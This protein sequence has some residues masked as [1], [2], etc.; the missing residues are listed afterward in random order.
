MAIRI[1]GDFRQ[2]VRAGVCSLVGF[3]TLCA[4]AGAQAPPVTTG[5]VV[6]VPASSSWGQIYKILFYQGNVLALDSGNDAL[7]QLAPGATSWTTLVPAKTGILGGGFNAQGMAID[8]VGNLYITVAYSLTVNSTALFWR[9]PYQ[10]GTW[11]VGASDGWGANLVD[12]N[13]GNALTDSTELDGAYSV[14]VFFQN[15]SKMDGSGTLY[16]W[17]TS[18]GLWSAPVDNTGN[19]SQSS[20]NA[21]QILSGTTAGQ[22][23]I[24][25][26]AAGNIYFVEYHGVKNSGRDTGIWFIPAAAANPVTGGG[27]VGVGP[28]LVRIDAAQANSSAPIVYAGL[29]LDAN[30][31]LYLTSENNSNYDETVAGAWEIPNVCS[32]TGVNASNVTQC[33]NWN[34]TSMVAPVDGNQPL[35]IDSRGYLW[36]PSYDASFPPS[37]NNGP[38]PGVN[39]NPGIY[40]LVV[41][42]PGVLNLNNVPAGPS[43]VGSTPT[44]AGIL[45]YTFNST[46]TPGGFQ[47]SSSVPGNASAFGTTQTNPLPPTSTTGTPPAPCN[48]PATPGPYATYSSQGWCEL[49]VT[50][51]PTAPGPVSA[52]LT[53]LDSTN[54][55][56]PGSTVYVSG[57]GQGPGAALLNNPGLNTLA[58]GLKTPTQVA[59]DAMGDTWVA[60][61]GNKQ[62]LYFAAGS[63]N[64]AGQPIGTNLSAPTGVAVD[65]SGDVYIG[66]S[67]KVYEISCTTNS[68]TQ[69]TCAYG[70]QTT[71]ATGF[72]PNLNLAVDGS[73]DVYVADPENARVVKIPSPAQSNLINSNNELGVATSTAVTVGFGLT[74]PSAVAV[75]AFDNVYI[76]DSGNLYEELAAPFN[77]QTA[78]VEGTLGD[79]T[80]LAVDA[81]GSVIV[82]Q[83]GGLLRVPSVAGTLNANNASPL[84]T[85]VDIPSSSTTEVATVSITSPTGVALDQQGNL[86][87]SDTTSGANLYELN[88]V[89]GFVQ[90][91]VGLVP[92]QLTVQDVSLVNIGNSSSTP[93]TLLANQLA[94]TGGTTTED[95]YFSLATQSAGTPCDPTGVESVAP[96]ASCTLPVGFTPPSPPAGDT[97][98]ITYSGVTMSVPTNAVNFAGGTVNAGLQGT[99]L[100]GLE[101]TQTAAQPTLTSSSYPGAGS[102]VVTVTPEPSASVDYPNAIPYGTVTLT[103]TN[104]ANQQST[105]Q[106]LTISSGGTGGAPLAY[107]FPE[108]GLLGGTYTIAAA[109]SGSIDQLMQ[110]STLPST[111]PTTFTV[112]ATAPTITFA[113]AA[114]PAAGS[115]L[116]VVN[117]VTYLATGQK[118]SLT[119]TIASP[120]GTPTGT[121]TIMN[122][123][124]AV[125]TATYSQGGIWTFGTGSLPAGTYSLTA[126]YS[127]DQNFSAVNSSPAVSFQD[128]QPSVLLSASP[129]SVTTTAGTP[130]QTTITIQSLVGFSAPTGANITCE[131]TPQDT[132]P[133]YA[134]CTFSNPQPEILSCVPGTG[135]SNVPCQVI[136]ESSVLTLSSNIPVNIPPTASNVPLNGPH[137]SPLLPAS[138]FGLGLLGLALRRRAIFN[139][140]LL[141]LVCLVSLLAGAVVGMTSCTNSSYSKPPKV[142][143]YTTPSGPYNISIVV[144]NPSTG[145]VESLPF[146]V[147]V[148]INA[149]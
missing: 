119:A 141:N 136:T 117:G 142:P 15:S 49:W 27:L 33:L 124:Q 19:A 64:A 146:T 100:A 97:G 51:D 72:G 24:A 18:D 54:T 135:T 28:P 60:D 56:V 31:D 65:G 92:Q 10:N 35:A 127:G 43:P 83:N 45:Y 95:G 39:G 102:I 78:I 57:T 96:G 4:A 40:G 149:Q 134:E 130:V 50:M 138:F 116:Q 9:V 30:G 70:T 82:A 53:L 47:F 17:S 59:S 62:V 91:G 25:V 88:V 71:V 107:S 85:S 63:S 84:D 113:F 109:Y 44:T 67:G 23:K 79:V 76:A 29:T 125:G 112:N 110:P 5:S 105:V 14:E 145:A 132:V 143:T 104:T 21:T 52:E 106:T 89:N 129:A 22:S 16:F 139:R 42:A 120:L 38:Y 111:P 147:G 32:P 98:S 36:I 121:V 11:N 118:V 12:A 1:A 20:V 133:Y 74:A 126:A 101:P 115:D 48:A 13:T 69:S 2:W 87:V 148:T 41:W 58:A 144:S 137:S 99:A 80:G 108:T 61:P 86:Y 103:L 3:L 26:D 68:S 46:V 75:D 140:Y 114:P 55:P 77:G 34:N 128:I 93:L 66:D 7:Y 123:T 122:G 37:T 8:A 81:S 131:V 94:F 73:G 6:T 90:F